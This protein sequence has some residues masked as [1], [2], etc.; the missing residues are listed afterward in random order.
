MP[1]LQVDVPQKEVSYPLN[2]QKGIL[3]QLDEEVSAIFS[4]QKIAIISDETVFQH[5]GEKTVKNLEDSGFSVQ[6]VVLPPGEQ[7]KTF[8]AMPAIY[9]QLLDFGLTR[10]DCIV[11]L[12]G[13]V[14]GDIAGFVA[15][16]F[17]RGVT[18][19]Q[20]P[21]TLL[22]QVDSSVGG[23]VGVD[24]PEG[25]NLVGAFY[26]PELVLIDPLV[27]E[28]L[29]DEYFSDGMAEVIKYGCIKDA[30]FFSQLS[31][32]SSRQEVMQ[33]IE[34]IIET[35]C[36]IKREVV[37]KDEKDKGERMLLNFGHTLGHA[38]EAYYQYKLYSHGQAVAIGMVEIMKLAEEKEL[39]KEGV[40]CEISACLE[41]H[42]LPTALEKV[43]DYSEILPY[44]KKDKKN[45]D[46]KLHV[47]LLDKIGQARSEQTSHTFFDSLAEGGQS[48]D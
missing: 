13:G 35:C 34:T 29:T 18:F 20:V 25:K 1:E 42:G 14:V 22:A 41:K 12:G 28:T 2:I 26:H 5:Y 44:I 27:L 11:A 19:V 40:A 6:S 23:K 33:K 8:D 46:G 36:A 10:S 17:L 31:K 16:S 9:S 30:S 3:N 45:L 48:F 47:V 21:T 43:E 15:A 38:I 32:L 24:L 4:G 37:Q 7:T 39:S